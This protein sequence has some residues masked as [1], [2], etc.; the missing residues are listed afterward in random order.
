MKKSLLAVAV[1]A[2]LPA[3]A[4]AQTQVTLS[5]MVKTGYNYVDVS[6]ATDGTKGDSASA[7][8]DGS[9]R[10]VISGT[11]NLGGGL[12]ATFQWDTRLR[13]DEA[14]SG[15]SSLGSGASWVGLKGQSWGELRIGRLD[16]YYFRGSDRHAYEA[17]ALQ[18]WNVGI[19][20]Y[21]GGQVGTGQTSA[22]IANAS[23]TN[24]LIRWD[25]PNWGGFGGGIGYSTAFQGA[26]AVGTS[27]KGAAMSADVYYASGPLNVGFSYWD[28]DFE[29]KSTGGQQAWRLY[30]TWD[31]G[32]FNVGFTWD[33]SEVKDLA[34]GGAGEWKR[35]AWSI[36]VTVK[37]GP[38][39][40]IGA[41]TMA[42]DRSVNGSDVADS[43]A[44]M[45]SIG[46]DYPL[47]KRTSVG[48]SYVDLSND[49]NAAYSL[50]TGGALS[51]SAAVR[52]GADTSQL[53]LGLLHRF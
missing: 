18:A 14:T 26:E 4:Y 47:S 6:D 8:A 21:V 41:Y 50:F 28:A 32:M 38:G 24:N 51:T 16:Q 49:R 45:W 35:D 39:K 22:A 46:Y 48:L 3:F 36:P 20:S 40:L 43:G 7:I 29:N 37:L 25:S 10:F 17:T 19:L 33:Q 13:P 30:G 2:A 23:R 15:Q 44:K 5:G 52:N 27:G 53:Y 9:S 42:D 1:A 31:F 34:T 11:E 12:M